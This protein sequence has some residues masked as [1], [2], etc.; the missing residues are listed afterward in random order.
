M[1]KTHQAVMDDLADYASPKARLTLLIKSGALIQVRRGLFV[2]NDAVSR[3]ALAPAI[4]G[5][6]Y[7]SFQYALA[8]YGLIPERAYAVTSASYG[9][10]RDKL[11]RTPLGEYRY[12]YLPVSVYPYGLR[13]DE[14]D[15]ANYLIATA[16][17]ALCDAV[18][19]V[20]GMRDR[21]DVGKLLLEEWR[22]EE[23]ELRGLDRDFI[24]WIAPRYG[25]RSVSALASWL[26]GAA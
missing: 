23:D 26:E 22:M 20:S 7:I 19:K 14:D 5:P 21:D 12:L 9:K 17:K 8:A 13:Q 15:G 18:Y 25:R 11:F 2:E 10:N 16:E 3:R 1:I 4:Y 24:R 6:S